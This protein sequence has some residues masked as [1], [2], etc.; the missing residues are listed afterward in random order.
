MARAPPPM[1]ADVVPDVQTSELSPKKRHS[2]LTT[3]VGT[4]PTAS[5]M[6][7]RVVEAGVE[8]GVEGEALLVEEREGVETVGGATRVAETREGGAVGAASSGCHKVYSCSLVT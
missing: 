6:K 1:P 7:K 5:T 8:A 2:P 4:L 3:R